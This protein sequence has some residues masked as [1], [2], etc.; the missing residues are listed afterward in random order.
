VP[1]I[2]TRFR[3]RSAVKV[4]TYRPP[5]PATELTDAERETVDAF[6]RLYYDAWRDRRGTLDLAWFGHRTIKCPFD[7]WTYQ[8][9]LVDTRPDVIVESGTAFGGSALYVAT[10]LDALGH[11]R[12]VSIDIE[13]RGRPPRHPRIEYLTGSSVDPAILDRVRRATAGSRTMVILDSDHSQAHVAA[14]LAAYRD[15]V[16]VGCYLV[17]EDTD[18]NGH[19]AR[20]D[21][22]PGPME[23]LEAF[24]ASTD[25]FVSD[26][27]R[28]R[29]LLTMNPRG[30][31]RRVS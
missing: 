18:I 7:L 15:I 13:T 26:G 4:G 1:W 31:L 20:P 9:I 3:G 2:P 6:H 30:F 19:P 11:G 24:L 23:A 5:S 25:D 12:V 14:E 17:V 28:E 10:L 27:S 16:S 8:E 29:F 22:G 21:F